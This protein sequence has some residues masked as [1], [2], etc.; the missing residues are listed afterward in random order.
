MNPTTDVNPVSVEIVI[1][2]APDV[3]N[4]NCVDALYVCVPTLALNMLTL[5]G[6]VIDPVPANN[7]TTPAVIVARLAF[8]FTVTKK[9]A[10]VL[11]NVMVVPVFVNPLVD[12]A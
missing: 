7:E 2:P 3:W 8:T 10:V 1:V 9:F 12:P 6:P 5:D 11:G 4:R